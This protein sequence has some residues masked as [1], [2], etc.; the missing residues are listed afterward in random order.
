LGERGGEGEE[1]AGVAGALGEA[2]G[3]ALDV[4]DVLE[5]L[6]AFGEEKGLGEEGFDEVLA[7]L[8]LSEV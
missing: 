3:A 5:G 8:E 2:A 6:A 7:G 1:V 4:A